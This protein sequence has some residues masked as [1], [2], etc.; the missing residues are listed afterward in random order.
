[1]EKGSTLALAT[2]MPSCVLGLVVLFG[3]GAACAWAAGVSN[4]DDLVIAP[5][6]QPVIVVVSPQA[7]PNETAAASDLVKY[8]ELLC[9]A[10]PSTAQTQDQIADALKLERQRVL[11]IVG[12]AALAADASLQ[13]ALDKVAKQGPVL[14][15]D[16]I[17]LRRSGNR[18]YLAGT[19][20]EAHYYA[21]SRLLHLWGCRW[22][23]PTE[24]GEC[25]PEHPE[26]RIGQLDVSYAP[27][28]EA[29]KYWISWN[30]DS[31]GGGW[32]CRS[33]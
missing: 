18:V 8:I 1:M 12:R 19:N 5:D 3:S 20:D 31:S 27:P 9:G 33:I 6:T 30:G 29:R 4:G 10:K 23:M 17:V 21:V 26:L 15:A 28:F 16:A 24:F 14:R 25:I 7:G 11:L 32:N 2:E 13:R 22:Y